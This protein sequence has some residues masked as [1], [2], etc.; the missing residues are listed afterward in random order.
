MLESAGAAADACITARPADSPFPL[1]A[2]YRDG[3]LKVLACTTTLSAGVNLPA[4]RV[5]VRHLD[6]R[7]V[8]GAVLRQMW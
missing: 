3:V 5:L 6:I 1:Q 4:R 2:A 7:A 8:D